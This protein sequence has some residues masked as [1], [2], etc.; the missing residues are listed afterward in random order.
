MSGQRAID[1]PICGR[2]IGVKPHEPGRVWTSQQR[3]LVNKLDGAGI[4]R[5]VTARLIGSSVGGVAQQVRR[6]KYGSR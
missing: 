5:K 1:C 6:G 3:W 4:S 2:E